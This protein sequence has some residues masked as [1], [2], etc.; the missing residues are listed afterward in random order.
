VVRV[1][2]SFV[3]CVVLSLFVLFIVCHFV[4]CPSSSYG[5]WLPTL[6]ILWFTASDYLLCLFY[7]LRLLITYFVYPMIYGFWLPTLSILWFTTSDYLL[8]LSYDLRLLITYFVYPMIYGFWLP[9]VFPMIYGFW[10]PTLSIL[11]FTASDY[12][13][14]LS[15]SKVI[16]ETDIP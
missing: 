1:A 14:C 4:F 11:W 8:C 3:F 12:P 15:L 10:L 7:D 16:G 2:Q 6:S 5:F 13:L 9:T